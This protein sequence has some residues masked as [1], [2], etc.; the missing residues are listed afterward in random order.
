M[1]PLPRA[2]GSQPLSRKV[3]SSR[4]FP[5]GDARQNQLE[6][7]PKYTNHLRHR[8]LYAHTQ[9]DTLASAHY[10]CCRP[11]HS[12]IDAFSRGPPPFPRIGPCLCQSRRQAA[13]CRARRRLA[14]EQGEPRNGV[15]RQRYHYW[16]G[17][18]GQY[19]V[20]RPFSDSAGVP[21]AF[22]PSCSENH[23][24]G[25]LNSPKLKDAG[26]VFVVSVN[27]PFV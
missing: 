15:D 1:V 7:A 9:Y 25:Y 10:V 4:A 14:R 17:S 3:R 5:L 27:D 2:E 24:P 21:A 22:S 6:R 16:Y 23:I 20:L 8:T 19:R 12:A 11:H 18:R 13:R 26:K